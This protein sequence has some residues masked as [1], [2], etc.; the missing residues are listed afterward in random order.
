MS[1]IIICLGPGGVGKTTVAASIALSRAKLGQ[2]AL[3]LTID[4]ANR[5]I[6]MLGIEKAKEPVQ[7]KSFQNGGALY[8]NAVDHENVFDHFVKRAAKDP[9]RADVLIENKLYKQLVSKLSGS[10]DFSALESLLQQYDEKKYDVIVLDTPPMHHVIGFLKSPEQLRMLFSDGVAKWFRL[11]NEG[12]KPFLQR[13]LNAGTLKMLAILE[14]LTGSDF[15]R[16]L[17]LFFKSIESW[18]G[19]LL[20]RLSQVS[21]L[22]KNPE[23]HFYMVTTAQNLR[24][25]EASEFIGTMAAEG[26]AIEK[27]ILNRS[28]FSWESDKSSEL[29]GPYA[30]LKELW[31]RSIVERDKNISV[32]KQKVD[33]RLAIIKLVEQEN[34]PSSI[35]DLLIMSEAL[36]KGLV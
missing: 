4:P 25:E 34:D 20:A 17:A 5:L 27:V 24:L 12:P 19:E 32:F 30:E 7:V 31:L 9:K 16:E 10:Q 23:T 15:V 35:E 13:M 36:Q 1:Q 14:K 18:R 29:S 21:E 6:K 8:A 2:K 11:G 33:T 28:S 26:I 22:L 3:V